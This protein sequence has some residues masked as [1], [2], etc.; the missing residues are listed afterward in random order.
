[1]A[2]D[3]LEIEIVV[4]AEMDRVADHGIEAIIN[5]NESLQGIKV[6]LLSRR[7]EWQSLLERPFLYLLIER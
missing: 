5:V 7:Q 3:A 4:A 6:E 1:M 2:C